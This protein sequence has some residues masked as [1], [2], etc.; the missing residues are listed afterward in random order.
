MFYLVFFKN[1]D[2]YLKMSYLKVK[3][4][5]KMQVL[6]NKFAEL[7]K[8]PL[9]NLR[10]KFISII[11]SHNPLKECF[12]WFSQDNVNIF[13]IIKRISNPDIWMIF[14]YLFSWLIKKILFYW[15]SRESPYSLN[16]YIPMRIH[17]LIF[18]EKTIFSWFFKA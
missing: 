11:Y 16:E 8:I 3:K 13:L 14:D 2:N 18:K 1:K 12:P 9:E 6:M 17:V 4:T 10:F 15:F 5:D 7:K